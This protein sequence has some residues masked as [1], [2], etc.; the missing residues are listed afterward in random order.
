MYY[1]LHQNAALVMLCYYISAKMLLPALRHTHTATSR[2]T[3][4][5]QQAC[6]LTELLPRPSC[7]SCIPRPSVGRSAPRGTC[8]THDGVFRVWAIFDDG[9]GSV[10]EEFI[11][12]GVGRLIC[13]PLIFETGCVMHRGAVCVCA[14]VSQREGGI[15]AR[16]VANEIKTGAFESPA[17]SELSLTRLH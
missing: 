1:V 2:K 8:R 5:E 14:C 4:L 17:F 13:T 10:G 15:H 12:N 7:P 9:V 16:A 11:W 3:P 6:D